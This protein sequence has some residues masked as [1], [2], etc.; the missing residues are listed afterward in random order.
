MTLTPSA[1]MPRRRHA[2]SSPRRRGEAVVGLAGG[3]LVA[4]GGALTVG[5]LVAPQTV[6]RAYGTVKT[7][8]DAVVDTTRERVTGEIPTV[9][10]GV[11]GGIPELDRCDGSFTEMTSYEHDDVP[12]VWAAHN[13]CGGDAVLPWETGQHLRVEGS[14]QVYEVVDIRHTS[15]VWSTTDDLVGLDG[16]LALQTC[17]YGED[18]MKFIGLRPLPAA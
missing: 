8:T 5:N 1:L 4:A 13:T 15:K 9:R 2:R 6:E 16:D 14:D 10:L 17:H 11:S 3:L 18:R 7:T 12:A